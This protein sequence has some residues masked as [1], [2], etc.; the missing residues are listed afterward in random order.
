MVLPI[1]QILSESWDYYARIHDR[2]AARLLHIPTGTIRVIPRKTKPDFIYLRQHVRGRGY[3]E[4]PIG[5]A[6]ED[7]AEGVRT[8]WR[9][10]HTLKQELGKA[11]KSL[12]LLKQR[13]LYRQDLD[14]A[15]RLYHLAGLLSCVTDPI[16][17]IELIETTAF[18]SLHRAAGIAY[19][20]VQALCFED[21]FTLKLNA[22]NHETE[23][24]LADCGFKHAVR[25][26]QDIAIHD[27]PGAGRIEI[28]LDCKEA[29][30]EEGRSFGSKTGQLDILFRNPETFVVRGVHRSVKL[31]SPAA[32]YLFG[33]TLLSGEG[34]SVTANS[35]KGRADRLGLAGQRI[36]KSQRLMNEC[37]RRYHELPPRLQDMV[38]RGVAVAED[39]AIGASG[40]EKEMIAGCMKCAWGVGV[41]RR[42]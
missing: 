10:G 35:Q 38:L 24:V 4:I 29:E 12:D 14:Y 2:L 33:L 26:D 5:P 19:R 41:V 37:S 31:P 28:P 36:S 9:E 17:A 11:K 13:K 7:I 39:M 25:R 30:T 32:Y 16:L 21:P 22:C 1:E 15:S 8:F 27:L 23:N 42:V 3:I 6:D 20:P 34:P 18:S 40:K